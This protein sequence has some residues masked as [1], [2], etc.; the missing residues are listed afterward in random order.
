M[1]EQIPEIEQ[2]KIT[3]DSYYNYQNF[4]VMNL[5]L[6]RRTSLHYEEGVPAFYTGTRYF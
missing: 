6:D 2:S 1:N 5:L 4:A 3:Y